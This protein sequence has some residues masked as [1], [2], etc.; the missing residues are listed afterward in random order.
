[1]KMTFEQFISNPLG[2]NSAVLTVNARQTIM[3]SYA[4]KWDVILLRE[5]GNINYHLYKD[6]RHNAYYG[7]FKIPSETVKNFYYD[8][9]VKFT[10]DAR[11]GEGG[12][13]LFKYSVQFYSNDPSFVYTYA[14]VFNKNDMFIKEL[15]NRMDMDALRKPPKERNPHQNTGYVKTIV[16]AYLFM[17][18]KK[19]NEKPRF[20]TSAATYTREHL[21]GNIE[22]A[23][24]KI[25]NRKEK[26]PELDEVKGR[27]RNEIPEPA[28]EREKK[29]RGLAILG[30]THTVKPKTS[31]ISKSNGSGIG[32]FKANKGIGHFTPKGKK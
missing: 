24:E 8:V 5:N 13:D 27:E 30:N 3:D 23:D 4:K 2:R 16:F 31:T 20:E 26:N 10:A 7:H 9:V 6:D 12:R 11:V 21:S 1:M 19:L 32:H 17:K 28:K 14:Y 18:S 22:N 29:S 25:K 15:T